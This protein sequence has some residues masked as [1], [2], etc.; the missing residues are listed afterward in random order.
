MCVL[1]VF[2]I[3][4]MSNPL[5]SVSFLIEIYW[6]IFDSID[7]HL[8]VVCLFVVVVVLPRQGV[9]VSR[10]EAFVTESQKERTPLRIKKEGERE[11][12]GRKQKKDNPNTA[13][14][15]RTK[16][17]KEGKIQNGN[18]RD[19]RNGWECVVRWGEMRLLKR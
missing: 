16:G 9:G 1:A 5:S 18:G 12:R 10:K 3:A 11:G 2:L 14:R 8:F 13:T 15:E 17:R 4:T 6:Q 7:I 19:E